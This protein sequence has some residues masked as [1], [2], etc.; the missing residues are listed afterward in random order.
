[1][2]GFVFTQYTPGGD[3]K[4]PFE[5]LLNTFM[6][7]LHYTNGDATEALN[8]LTQLDRQYGLTDDEYG[9]GDFIE[10]LKNNGYLQGNGQNGALQITAKTE[11]TIRKRSLE[12]IFVD[13]VRQT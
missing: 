5:K 1:M 8:W 13:L 4:T 2:Q 3:D 7:L 12:E 9:I 6:E 11:Q 10:D